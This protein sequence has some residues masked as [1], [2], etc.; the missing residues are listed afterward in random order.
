MVKVET[1][2]YISLRVYGK[3]FDDISREQQINILDKRN[4]VMALCNMV[5]DKN[6]MDLKRN[7]FVSL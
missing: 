7:G 6:F 5:N 4:S 1:I 2:K 3:T